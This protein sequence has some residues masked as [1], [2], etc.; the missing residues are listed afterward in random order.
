MNILAGFADI[1]L[2]QI[3]LVGSMAPLASV[4]G[5]LAGRGTGAFA[6]AVVVGGL[7]MITAALR[8]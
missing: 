6:A 3:A 2:G 8:H 1:S 7:V 5:G 4:I